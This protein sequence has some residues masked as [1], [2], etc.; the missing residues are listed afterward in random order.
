MAQLVVVVQILVAER[1]AED[2]LP[3]QRRQGVDRGIHAGERV[4]TSG[5]WEEFEAV[6]V[7]G[8]R[9]LIAASE[10]AGVEQFVHVSSLSVYDVPRDGAVIRED[11]PLESGAG[12]RGSYARSKLE[13]DLVAQEAMERG[14]PVTIVRPGLIFG[15]GRRVPLARRSF[16]AGPLRLL[17]A[18]RGYLMPMAFV[19]NVADGLV[20]ASRAPQA[21]GR[22]YTLV[23]E[24]VPQVE[25]VD[26][27]RRASG[28]SFRVIFIPPG[29]V[30]VGV[31]A[32]ESLARLAGRK[33]PITRHQV[34]RTLR[35]ATFDATRLRS[36]LNWSPPV[37]LAQALERCF[38]ENRVAVDC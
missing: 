4:A 1:D 37:S 5:P 28:E 29:L 2:A 31:S 34:E 24:H 6:N 30:R 7:V 38:S 23:D 20:A 35:S 36:E 15:P 25:Y 16:A 21:I 13:A 3:K 9:E 8:T 10:R 11:S 12:E 18:S 26:M 19:D 27:V 17:L 32:V 33:S 22:I 14:A